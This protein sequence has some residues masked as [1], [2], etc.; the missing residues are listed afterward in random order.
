MQASSSKIISILNIRVD[1]HI[2]IAWQSATLIKCQA[3]VLCG[4]MNVDVSHYIL[5]FK[6]FFKNTCSTMT[7]WIH[8]G[9]IV[10]KK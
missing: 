5:K 9:L 4:N 10:V 6:F 1:F 8:V 2:Y 3:D 7:A